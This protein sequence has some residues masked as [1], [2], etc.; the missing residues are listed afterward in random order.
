M[1]FTSSMAGTSASSSVSTYWSS[2]SNI[3]NRDLRRKI[4]DIVYQCQDGH[5][6]SAFSILEILSVLYSNVL[7]FKVEQPEWPERDYFVLSK[8]HGSLALYV[9]L[10][11]HGFIDEDALWKFCKKGGTLGMHPDMNKIPGVDASTGSLGHGFPY[12]VGVALGEQIK[13]NDNRTFALIGDSEAHEGT[14]WEAAHL[15]CNLRLG[16]L[17]VIVDLNESAIQLLPQDDQ[18]A[19]WQAFGWKTVVID[20]HDESALE[21]EFGAIDYQLEGQ[22]TVIIAKTV[23]GKGVPLLEG[24]GRWHHRT[25]SDEEYTEIIEALQ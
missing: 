2:M 8:G 20:G 4:I 5:I 22:P 1:V 9:T 15:A 14:I 10:A 23:K 11:R 13:Q 16:N 19:K 12:A 24:H 3:P 21:R 18:V 7:K 17:C 25:P 6:P